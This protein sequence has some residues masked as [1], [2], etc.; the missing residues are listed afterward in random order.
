MTE[1]DT[2]KLANTRFSAQ[3][4]FYWWLPDST[5]IN[6]RPYQAGTVRGWTSV[7]QSSI[8]FHFS[9]CTG[10]S[11][12]GR[13]LTVACGSRCHDC[14]AGLVGTLP[15]ARSQPMGH[16]RQENCFGIPAGYIGEGMPDSEPNTTD[17]S[18]IVR[19]IGTQKSSVPW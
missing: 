1:S 18:T 4:L 14:H 3:V 15:T 9:C 10:T 17:L 2:P 16:R 19:F 12:Y 5:F 8:F 13:C 7:A 11:S 6:L